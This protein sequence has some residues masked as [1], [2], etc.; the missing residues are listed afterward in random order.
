[1]EK[2]EYRV[3]NGIAE[4]TMNCPKNLNALDGVLNRELLE[5]FD[6]AENDPEVKVV[7]VDSATK[8]FGAGG[9]IAF[10]VDVI[11][12]GGEIDIDKDIENAGKLSLTIKKMSKIV[13]TA[14]NG[15][16]AG[17]ST[18][19]ALSGDVVV[20]ADNAKFMQSFINIGLVTDTG[21]AYLLSK[22]IGAARAFELCA[23][24]RPMSAEEGYQLG[25]VT[26]VVPADQLRDCAFRW[27]KKFCEGPLVAYAQLKKQFWAANYTAYEKYFQ[28]GEIPT[29][30]VV[31][32]TED[33]KEGCVAFFEKRKPN[34]KGK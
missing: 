24:G 14:V 33:F 8:I 22:S 15:A 18:N 1:M 29:Q 27:A 30:H 19:F 23:T 32:N 31:A 26:E 2:V 6:K 12:K 3:S 20:A 34:F 5:C 21:G 9:D 13:I 16:A 25:L 7:V 10:F 17:A 28:E 11:K 4:I